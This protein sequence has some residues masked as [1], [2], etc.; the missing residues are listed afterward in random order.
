MTTTTRKSPRLATPSKCEKR[1]RDSEEEEQ[2][3]LKIAKCWQTLT[4]CGLTKKC[5]SCNITFACSDKAQMNSLFL[6]D[7]I[8]APNSEA[9]CI[10]CFLARREKLYY[11]QIPAE[12]QAPILPEWNDT[13]DL[14]TLDDI[15]FDVLCFE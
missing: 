8:E 2:N 5:P 11:P 10:S 1:I 3:K 7:R 9:T 15:N 4:T 6:E 14:P 13:F 12:P